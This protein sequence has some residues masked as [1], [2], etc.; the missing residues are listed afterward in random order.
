MN[1]YYLIGAFIKY[2]KYME[3][4]GKIFAALKRTQKNIITSYTQKTNEE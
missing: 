3:V 2:W 4:S 1:L